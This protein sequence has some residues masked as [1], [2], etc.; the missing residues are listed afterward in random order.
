V[1]GSAG[2]NQPEVRAFAVR[3][4]LERQQ[5]LAARRHQLEQQDHDLQWS[6]L[7]CEELTARMERLHRSRSWRLTAPLRWM[8]RRLGRLRRQDDG[9]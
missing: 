7:A 9:P 3:L 6:R 5:R 1:I 4:E 2:G 8:S